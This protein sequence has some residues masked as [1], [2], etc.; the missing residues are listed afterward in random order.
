MRPV[1]LSIHPPFPSC[2]PAIPSSPSPLFFLPPS[3]E[4][5][6]EITF[7]ALPLLP[8]P[9]FPSTE[10]HLLVFERQTPCGFCIY[11]FVVLKDALS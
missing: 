3:F 4:H 8:L 6:K 9:F 10:I 1:L 5:S 11:R 2:L 7:L